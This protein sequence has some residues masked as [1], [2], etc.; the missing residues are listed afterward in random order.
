VQ[1]IGFVVVSFKISDR[2][3]VYQPKVLESNAEPSEQWAKLFELEAIKAI[4]KWKF[5]YRDK[6]CTARYKFTFE[7]AE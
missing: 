1:Q 4:K 2:G 7:A 6:A 5:K 3:Y